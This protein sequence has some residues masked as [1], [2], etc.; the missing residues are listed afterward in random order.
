MAPTRIFESVQGGEKWGRYSLIGLQTSTVLRVYG[1]RLEIICD[2]KP[3]V[4]RHTDDPMA[5]VERF[6]QL[7]SVPDLQIYPDLPAV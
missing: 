7:F 4:D 1:Q 3:M 5:E 2:G 6:R